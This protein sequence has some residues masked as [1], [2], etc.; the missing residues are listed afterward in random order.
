LVAQI[1]TRDGREG[2]REEVVVGYG[3]G[4]MGKGR[5]KWREMEAAAAGREEMNGG[6]SVTFP[7]K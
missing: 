6:K 7:A 3:K 4:G 1:I 2:V 5:I